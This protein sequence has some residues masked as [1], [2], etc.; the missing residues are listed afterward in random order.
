MHGRLPGVTVTAKAADTVTTRTAVTNAEGVATLEALALS[1]A[2]EITAE[3]AGFRTLSQGN[4]RAIGPDHD[5]ARDAH[6]WRGQR[7]RQ[8]HRQQSAGGY[9]KRDL[10][11][12]HHAAV[13]RIAADRPQLSELP[14]DDPRR[15][16]RRSD[17]QR[18]PAAR[19]GI[20]YSDI[21]G[22]MGGKPS[23]TAYYFEGINVTDLFTRT[24]V[25]R[26]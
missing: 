3:L 26:T 16:A 7:G 8:R 18:Q 9:A 17:D 25:G 24:F 5:A 2:H 20:N 21:A 14:S 11:S 23:D 6:A 22:N 10:G 12:R 1:T 4:A 15:H 13:D 19:G